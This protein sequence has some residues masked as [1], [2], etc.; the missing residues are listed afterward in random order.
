MWTSPCLPVKPATLKTRPTTA[1]GQTHVYQQ[2]WPSKKQASYSVDKPTSTEARYGY[3]QVYGSKRLGLFI[4]RDTS[5]RTVLGV[6]NQADNSYTCLSQSALLRFCCVSAGFCSP[7]K[8]AVQAVLVQGST[9]SPDPLLNSP[10][11]C[12]ARFVKDPV[13]PQSSRSHTARGCRAGT[14]TAGR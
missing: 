12:P 4:A 14:A 3:I 1:H 13:S 11:S 6:Q 9:L 8:A 7:S 10:Q 5:H 2:N